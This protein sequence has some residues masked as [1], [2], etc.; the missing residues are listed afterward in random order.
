MATISELDQVLDAVGHLPLEDQEFLLQIVS[1]RVHE[2]RR[3][4]C[5]EDALE[6]QREFAEGKLQ[7][8]S[9]E[10]LMKELRS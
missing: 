3:R 4:E 2:N 1:R 6:G 8:M 7:A 10:A 9:V 5:I